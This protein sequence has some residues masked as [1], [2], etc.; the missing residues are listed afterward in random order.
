ME[1]I[2]GVDD[3]RDLA[4]FRDDHE[5]LLDADRYEPLSANSYEVLEY[6]YRLLEN[7]GSIGRLRTDEAGNGIESRGHLAYHSHCQQR[8]LGL[9]SYTETVLE[10]TG[11][12]VA[13]V[14]RTEL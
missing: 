11:Y 6:V 2:V 7:G 13:T 5:K 8:M 4:M 3:R 10:R 14:L 1:R 9:E 12:D